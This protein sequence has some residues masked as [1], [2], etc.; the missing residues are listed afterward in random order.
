MYG[1][2]PKKKPMAKKMPM[3]KKAPK[4]RSKLY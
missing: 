1:K 4:R 2:R 3:K